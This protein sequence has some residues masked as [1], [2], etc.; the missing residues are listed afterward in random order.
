M[1]RKT[2]EKQKN[3]SIS[4]L[5][6]LAF[7][8]LI[9]PSV[10]IIDIFPDFIAYLIIARAL[11]YAANR[12]PFFAEAR[13]GL[14][15]L[16]LLSIFKLPMSVL[17]LNSRANDVG[18]GD[19]LAL[20]AFSFAVIEL[21]LISAL[22]KDI[23][24]A[25]FY[26]GERSDSCPLLLPFK[27]T[28]KSEKY[29]SVEALRTLTFVFFVF[30][31]AAYSLPE[32]LLLTRTVS[33]SQMATAFNFAKLYPYC[34]IL[35][36][37]ATVWFGV[38]WARRALS[39]AG[40]I[41]EG[42][43]FNTALDS[44]VADSGREGLE[45]RLRLNRLKGAVTMLTIAAFFAIDVRFD[46]VFGINLLPD[47]LFGIALLYALRRLIRETDGEWRGIYAVGIAF[48]II[49]TVK[50]V[51]ESRFLFVH[52]YEV[53]LISPEARTD[54]I[55]VMALGAIE[56]ALIVALLLMMARL[57]AKF[58]I[59]HTGILPDSDKYSR[60]DLDYHSR[61]KKKGYALFG[62]GIILYAVKLTDCVFK[63]FSRNTLVSVGSGSGLVSTGLVP[64]FGVVVSLA[65]VAFVG[66][67]LYFGSELKEEL[68]LKYL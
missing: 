22:L 40:A 42:S 68:E 37:I 9:N 52:G 18:N 64:W 16:S 60:T 11:G 63:L 43:S 62:L 10:N 44:M 67:A 49:S 24:A 21:T 59:A 12:A 36:M 45:S 20:F 27:K 3:K 8:I 56:T 29:I 57:L 55:V 28:K 48:T 1:V 31:C 41:G 53:M 13:S 5:L 19:V 65:T 35:V 66:Y 30:K 17:M 32:L 25:L 15:K 50:Y 4:G 34:L 7:V 38:V 51:L 2:N 58:I 46:N 33:A 61:L 47:L 39:Y 26:L 23:F 54:Y 14:Y 6:V